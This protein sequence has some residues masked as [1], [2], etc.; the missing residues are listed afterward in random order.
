MVKTVGTLKIKLPQGA[1]MYL[2]LYSSAP[3]P[4]DYFS[5]GNL[6]KKAMPQ[7]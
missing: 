6:G 7:L 1:C 2:L 5:G 3:L 4:T